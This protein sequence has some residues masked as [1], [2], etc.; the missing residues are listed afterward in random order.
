M[1]KTFVKVYLSYELSALMTAFHL[2]CFLNWPNR[3]SF[4]ALA[5]RLWLA[6]LRPQ[7]KAGVKEQ[8]HGQ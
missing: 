3:F 8:P 7:S 2:A 4:V 1:I 6:F 5:V